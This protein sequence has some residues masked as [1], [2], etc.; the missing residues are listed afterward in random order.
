MWDG[1]GNNKLPGW[2]Y[3][4]II[5]FF[6]SINQFNH[7]SCIPQYGVHRNTKQMVWLKCLSDAP[8]KN[9][10]L[11]AQRRVMSAKTI[12]FDLSLIQL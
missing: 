8:V 5:V 6:I 4:R 1:S 9:N 12:F 7:L 2:K 11:R 3:T 10:G